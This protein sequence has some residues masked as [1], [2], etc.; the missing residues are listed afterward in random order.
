MQVAIPALGESHAYTLLGGSMQKTRQKILEYLKDHDEATVEELS[1][2]LNDLTAVTVRHHLDVL[3]GEGL[4]ATPRVR[5]RDTPGRPRYV[6]SL[7]EK[8]EVFFPKNLGT[9]TGVILDEIQGQFP[10]DRVNV[11]FTSIARRMADELEPGPPGEP[12]EARLDRIVEHLTEHG[13][14]ASWE[15]RADGYVLHTGNCPYSTIVDGHDELCRVDLGYVS[16]LLGV[17]SKR[18]SHKLDGAATC[19]YFVRLPEQVGAS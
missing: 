12:F 13:Y 1:E 6:Y 11:V 17:A 16:E 9:L 10:A 2:M 8:A 4:V 7:T 5:H 15:R 14:D 19:S 3:R 18:L